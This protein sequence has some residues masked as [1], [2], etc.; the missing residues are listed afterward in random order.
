MHSDIL[1][2]MV[3]GLVFPEILGQSRGLRS[4][5]WRDIHEQQAQVFPTQRNQMRGF[6]LFNPTYN[7]NDTNSRLG[8]CTPNPT[9][10]IQAIVFNSLKN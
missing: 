4:L 2:Q 10:T 9:K 5:N 1:Q 6:A 3:V 7:Y 8:W